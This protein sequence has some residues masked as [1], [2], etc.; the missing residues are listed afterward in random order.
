MECFASR[1]REVEFD[2]VVIYVLCNLGVASS[3]ERDESPFQTNRI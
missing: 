2:E 1:V 3:F